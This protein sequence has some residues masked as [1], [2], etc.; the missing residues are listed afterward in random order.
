MVEVTGNVTFDGTPVSEGDI[1]FR[2]ADGTEGSCAGRIVDGSYTFE[3]TPGDKLVE[4]YAMRDVPGKFDE[5]NPGEKV[6]LREMY[7]PDN[8]NSDTTLKATVSE[9]GDNKFDFSLESGS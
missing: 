9:S 8:Y 6:P 4:V 5:S 2:A 7:I 3:C 1:T